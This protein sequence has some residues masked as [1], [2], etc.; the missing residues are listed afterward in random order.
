MQVFFSQSSVFRI[1]K[2]SKMEP[3]FS[4]IFLCVLIYGRVGQL[5]ALKMP[6]SYY[7][8]DGSTDCE[9]TLRALKAEGKLDFDFPMSK[10]PPKCRLTLSELNQAVRA[11]MREFVEKKMPND[12]NCL[13]DELAKSEKTM[14]LILIMSSIQQAAFFSESEKNF[15][16][17][18]FRNEMRTNL[19]EIAVKCRASEDEFVS[20]FRKVFENNETLIAMESTYCLA[21]YVTDKEILDLPDVNLNPNNIKIKNLNCSIVV[22]EEMRKDE[23]RV[24]DHITLRDEA[25][26]ACLMNVYKENKIFELAFAAL[27]LRD[28]EMPAE[29]K[30]IQR[31]KYDVK[32]AHL[33]A[34]FI[35]CYKMD[36]DFDPV[37]LQKIEDVNA[38]LTKAH[39][40]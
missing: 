14:D 37:L 16:L 7:E 36:K 22:E 27:V 18:N 5:D 20:L 35:N 17:I 30:Q 11:D 31:S 8:L 13:P 34:P 24:R 29:T 26:V 4:F 25:A 28:L 21:K 38:N 3:R 40:S 2:C 6:D 10:E 19:K 9:C 15:R 12:S 33:S 32:R 23:E 39:L 1:V